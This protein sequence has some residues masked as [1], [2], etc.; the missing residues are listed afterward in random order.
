MWRTGGAGPAVSGRAHHPPFPEGAAGRILPA[1]VLPG[2][3][4]HT[5]SARERHCRQRCNSA[6]GDSMHQPRSA[7]RDG[8]PGKPASQRPAASG[9]ASNVGSTDCSRDRRCSQR[10]DSAGGGSMHRSKCTGRG[11]FGGRIAGGFPSQVP[12][13]SEPAFNVSAHHVLQRHWAFHAAAASVTPR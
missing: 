12:A 13:A 4:G 3:I 9:P 7:G 2:A 8:F 11:G 1:Q 10:F 6:A 5:Y